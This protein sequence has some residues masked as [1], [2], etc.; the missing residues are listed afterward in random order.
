MAGLRTSLAILAAVVAGA[1]SSQA[2]ETGT[3]RSVSPAPTISGGTVVSGCA[4]RVRDELEPGL[5][6]RAVRAG[7]ASF[8]TYR[9]NPPRGSRPGALGNFKVMVELRPGA[10]VTV[11]L[12]EAS[13]G[14]LSLL[15]DRGRLRN[16]NAYTLADGSRRVRFETC[17]GKPTTFVGAVI[18]TGGGRAP[19][20]VAVEG[21]PS[22]RI[23]LV[24]R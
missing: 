19:L 9:I 4:M 21:G 7:P 3:A 13:T 2:P 20:D 8:V 1:C 14:R 17:P 18:T 24:A 16:D 12:P 6:D 22:Y 23:E 15:F 11:S 5:E 10:R